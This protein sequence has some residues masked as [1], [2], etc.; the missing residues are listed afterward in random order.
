MIGMINCSGPV[1]IGGVGGSG[2]RVAAMLLKELGFYIGNDLN[3]PND[4]LWFTLLLARSKWFAKSSEDEI[5]QGLCIFEKAMAGSL[6]L[7]HAEL[8]FIIR[9]AIDMSFFEYLHWA[10]DSGLLPIKQVAKVIWPV[11]SAISLAWAMKRIVTMIRT[12]KIDT[13]VTIGWGW[14]EPCSYIYIRFLNEYFDS[15]KY[16]HVIRNGLDMAYSS[17]QGHL[18]SWGDRFGVQIPDSPELLPKASIEYWIKANER[19]IAVGERLL[20]DRFLVL[21]FDKLCIE[22]R[23]QIEKLIS[24]LKIESRN[25]DINSLCSLCKIPQSLGRYKRYGLGI[26]CKDEIDAVRRLG[27]EI[28]N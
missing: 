6:G 3:L 26:F 24:F 12:R 2:T 25:L 22:P 18:Y 10:P 13:S 19:T 14:K 20:G 1:V 16:I 7:K 23:N 27:F 17:N 8:G 21:N 15:F 4:N 5:R 9:A 28:D 11:K